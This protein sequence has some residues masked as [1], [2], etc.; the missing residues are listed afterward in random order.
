MEDNTIGSSD[1]KASDAKPA[2]WKAHVF[3]AAKEVCL[4]A[5]RRGPSWQS[6][7]VAAAYLSIAGCIVVVLVPPYESGK[8]VCALGFGIAGVLVL[9]GM[10]A[11]EYRKRS[12]ADKPAASS[13]TMFAIQLPANEFEQVRQLLNTARRR[14]SE[15]LQSKNAEL[16]DSQVRANIFVSN[17]GQ[18]GRPDES[19]LEIYHGLHW[20]MDSHKERGIKLGLQQGV[21]GSVYRTGR[22]RVAL[23]IEDDAAEW[24]E[25]FDIT[26]E[27]REIIHPEL[28]WIVSMPIRDTQG[29]T[30]GVLNIDGLK[31]KFFDDD[32]YGC[33]AI[34]GPEV[35]MIGPFLDKNSHPIR[36]GGEQ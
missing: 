27:L 11:G 31:H 20:N 36:E 12:K 35:A 30:I 10:V 4:E 18:S 32:L 33:V 28:M 15:F 21:T 8:Q 23:R 34:A 6:F 9:A 17:A 5:I 14:V 1:K 3:E 19:F 2:S 7:F 13:P 26:A 29:R 22:S 24:E 25:S 16:Q